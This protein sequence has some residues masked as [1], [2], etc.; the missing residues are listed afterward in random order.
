MKYASWLK[1]IAPKIYD[2]HGSTSSECIWDLAHYLLP[3]VGFQVLL[4]CIHSAPK[5]IFKPVAY[6]MEVYLLA[7]YIG[8]G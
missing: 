7:I 6:L 4:F 1:D 3:G 8:V 2:F 5:E